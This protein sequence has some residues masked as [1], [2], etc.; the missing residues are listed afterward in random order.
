MPCHPARARKLLAA[1]KASIL[2]RFPFTIVLLNRE[3][4]EKQPVQ[5]KIDPGSKQTG[6]ALVAD[7]QR[8]KQ[9]I[10]AAVLEHRGEQ[11]K[12]ALTSRRSRRYSRRYRHTRYRP[13]RFH[14]RRHPESWLQ[15]SLQSRIENVWTWLCRIRRFCPLTSISQEL[16]KFDTHLMQNPEIDGI[17]YQQGE[18]QGYEVR[19]YLLEKWKRTCAYCGAKDVP[20]EI[21]HIVPRSRG[22]SNRVNNLT[23]ACHGCNQLKGNQ[24]AAEFGHSKLQQQAKQSLKDAAAINTTRWALWRRLQQTGLPVEVGTG[25]RTQWN[26][27]RQEYP[28]THWIDAA[29][30]GESGGYVELKLHHI[31]L[32]M[33]A[34]GHGRRQRCRT[35]A[36]GFPKVH[37][38]RAKS[39][40]GFKTGDMVKA[41]VPTG[42]YAGKHVGRIAIRFRP[43][44]RL[45]GIDVHPK[46]LTLLHCADGYEY[47]K[48]DVSACKGD[49]PR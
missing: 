28:K 20:L 26:R 30:V 2:R 3:G 39:F 49:S 47:R 25:G 46:Y 17:E 16:V 29:C 23:L 8:G 38:P 12:N 40:L 13:A 36:F 18:L 48:G 19:A 22:G 41:V 9:L 44:F 34:M 24:T 5:F 45:N 21:E 31:P 33:K 42:K 35:D 10:W 11:I 32:Y 4:G 37:L 1:G 27:T 6:L 7:F 43:R 15:P 14:N